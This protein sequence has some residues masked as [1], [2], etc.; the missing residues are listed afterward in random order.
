MSMVY[1]KDLTRVRIMAVSL[2]KPKDYAILIVSTLEPPKYINMAK[3]RVFLNTNHWN[4]K[5]LSIANLFYKELVKYR[6]QLKKTVK[7]RHLYRAYHN[8]ADKERTS[9]YGFY[10]IDQLYI[11]D[12]KHPRNVLANPRKGYK[13]IKSDTLRLW[14]RDEILFREKEMLNN[15]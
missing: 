11:N 2:K 14:L 10:G 8:I 6:Q 7:S 1:E 15:D 4:M 5:G 9:E 3:I 13:E 12:V